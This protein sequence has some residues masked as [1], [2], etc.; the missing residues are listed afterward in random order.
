MVLVGR[1]GPVGGFKDL[2]GVVAVGFVKCENFEV[3]LGGHAGILGLF[4]LR[5]AGLEFFE[6]HSF[7]GE[8]G[9]AGYPVFFLERVAFFCQ[10]FLLAREIGEP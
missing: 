5:P 6:F 8:T 9:V 4:L 10:V 3:L 1:L 2:T 7:Y